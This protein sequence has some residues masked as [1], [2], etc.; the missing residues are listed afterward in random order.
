[1]PFL[2]TAGARL[3]DPFG[4]GTAPMP[5][6]PISILTFAPI[7]VTL[8]LMLFALLRERPTRSLARKLFRLELLPFRGMQFLHSGLVGDYVAWMLI[9]LAA[10]AGFLAY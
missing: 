1:M 6:P 7:A 2:G 9:G 5:L 10:L 3:I 8:A 4:G